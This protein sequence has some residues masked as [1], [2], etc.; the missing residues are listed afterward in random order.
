MSEP[1]WLA[2]EAVLVFHNMVIEATGGTPGVRDEGLLDSALSR[3]R[4]LYGYEQ[5]D[6]IT[7]AA[8]YAEGICM[9]HPFV[10]GNK[11]TAYVAGA[12]FL[13]MH[14]YVLN[15]EKGDEHERT[16]LDLAAGKISMTELAAW[17]RDNVI[18]DRQSESRILTARRR[19]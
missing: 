4:N 13:Q 1:V 5:A 19:L 6:L 18:R 7:L 15:Q 10:D 14:G 8:S 2:K 11:R 17:Y 12:A 3:P 16:F 9:N